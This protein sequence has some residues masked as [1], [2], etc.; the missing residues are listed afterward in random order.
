MATKLI[1]RGLC[2]SRSRLRLGFGREPNRRHR[3]V[4]CPPARSGARGNLEV[5]HLP[6]EQVEPQ[7][8]PSDPC[9]PAVAGRSLSP[10]GVLPQPTARQQPR[11]PLAMRERAASSPQSRAAPSRYGPLRG[12]TPTGFAGCAAVTDRRAAERGG[13]GRRRTK[14]PADPAPVF[15]ETITHAKAHRDPRANL[16]AL[17]LL[18]RMVALREFSGP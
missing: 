15:R 17:H 16:Q 2:F 13:T 11:A 14:P 9:G 5:P 7:V 1:G 12:R 4:R 6:R 3:G 10:P 8:E 18:L